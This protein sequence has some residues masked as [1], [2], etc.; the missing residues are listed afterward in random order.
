MPCPEPVEGLAS[1]LNFKEPATHNSRGENECLY[2]YRA[3]CAPGWPMAQHLFANPQQ[4]SEIDENDFSKEPFLLWPALRIRA[5]E[6]QRFRPNS[7]TG[8]RVDCICGEGIALHLRA[9]SG[10]DSVAVSS[11]EFR[12][13]PHSALNW[14]RATSLMPLSQAVT[15]RRSAR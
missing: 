8:D 12:V 1:D 5:L 13:R 6:A 10:S 11:L 14:K 2:Q 7:H 3:R 15:P 4:P 9:P